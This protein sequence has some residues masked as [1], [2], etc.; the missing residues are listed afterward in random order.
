MSTDDVDVPS[1]G[2]GAVPTPPELFDMPG[3]LSRRLYQAYLALWGKRVDPV[4]TGPQFGVLS[5]V[6]AFP[7]SDQGSVAAAVVLDR[8][9][10]A[11][12]ARR[13]ESRGL[14]ERVADDADGRRKLLYLSDEGE[15][16]LAEV[17]RRV[18]S[19][20]GPLLAPLSEAEQVAFMAT[21]RRIADHWES[22]A[23]E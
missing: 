1:N 2:P 4:L 19:L 23:A 14:L 22:L 5:A 3:Y 17:T 7:G 6:Q 15:K 16:V 9:T 20:T 12:V 21:L 10:M 13:L 11:D 18:A 8:S